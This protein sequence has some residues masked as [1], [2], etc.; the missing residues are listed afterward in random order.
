M[1]FTK[2][3]AIT[4]VALAGAATLGTSVYAAQTPGVF[5]DRANGLVQAIATKFNLNATEVQQVFDE[6]REQHQ[7]EMQA[8]N[9]ER[10]N[11]RLKQAVTDGKLTQ[12]QADA[13]TAK[14]EEM[15]ANMEALKDKTQEERQAAIKTQ[16]ESLKQWA[17][18]NNIPA[19]YLPMGFG[20]GRGGMMGEGHA[21]G[22]RGMG[23]M[24]GGQGFNAAQGTTQQQ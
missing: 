21:G 7:T 2:S 19:G 3:L 18:D 12:A 17:T 24:R 16:M 14:H 22:G 5:Q 9:E 8:K 23:K 10:L 11:E 6:Q 20:P 13:I 1:N 15:Q 4:A